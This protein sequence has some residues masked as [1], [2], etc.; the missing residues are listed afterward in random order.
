MRGD[1]MTKTQ[2]LTF[3]VEIDWPSGVT[4][5]YVRQYVEDA[6]GTWCG[7]LRPPR[8]WGDDDPGDPLWG[9]GRTVKVKR[10]GRGISR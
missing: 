6:V 8:A 1:E 7:T 5:E 3:S 4:P 9:V 10:I 2:R